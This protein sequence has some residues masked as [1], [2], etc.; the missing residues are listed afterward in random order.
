MFIGLKSI[1]NCPVLQIAV[2]HRTKSNHI[3]HVRAHAHLV[4]TFSRT[5]LVR[6]SVSQ[7]VVSASL[8]F[9]PA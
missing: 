3:A 9:T 5:Q 4:G 7:A 8:L 6:T 1:V 2:G